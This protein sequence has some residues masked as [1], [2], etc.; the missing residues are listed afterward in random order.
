MDSPIKKSP[1]NSTHEARGAR[2][3]EFGGWRLPVQ[4]A[5]IL[6][7]HRAVRTRAGLFDISHM[8]QIC[9]S[10]PRAA[11]WL[12]GLLTND[13]RHL[14]PGAGHYTLHLNE[15]GGVLDDMLCYRTGEDAFLLVVNAARTREVWHVLQDGTEPGVVL[16]NQSDHWAGIALQ[17]PSAQSI[18]TALLGESSQIP[19]RNH[20]TALSLANGPVYLARTGYTGED[21]FEWF[22]PVQYAAF[23]WERLL[24]AGHSSEIA[25]CGLGARDTL[26][27]EAGL[28]LNGNDLS[29]DKTP[30]EAGLH[31]FVKL[32]KGCFLGKPALE[33]QLKAGVPTRL[34]ALVLE[35]KTP[36]PR[37][38]YPVFYEGTAV[39]ETC[40]GT[41][42]P[43]LNAGIA[44]AYLP[45]AL[46]EIGTRV[47]VKI[48]DRSFPANVTRKPFY[49]RPA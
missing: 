48:R 19:T 6:E 27:L 13:I 35:G 47:E 31:R 5:G 7:E 28:P 45:T 17:G 36:P 41:H 42:S 24:E 20:I 40:S 8:G 12:N 39:G 18:L 11:A 9:A 43:T 22:C 2:M 37:P 49:K 4:F 44:M 1:L 30:L 29:P 21:G 26:R 25:P 10:G 46:A 34:S 3:I 38:H 15:E 14:K 16:E 32:E 33:R 23:W